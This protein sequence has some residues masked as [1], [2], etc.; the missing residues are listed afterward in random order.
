MLGGASTSA[1]QDVRQASTLATSCQVLAWLSLWLLFAI[2]TTIARIVEICGSMAV[3]FRSDD[4]AS[5]GM[6]KLRRLVTIS[7]PVDKVLL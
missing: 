5:V 6:A 3:H 1:S 4:L 7:K 2:T